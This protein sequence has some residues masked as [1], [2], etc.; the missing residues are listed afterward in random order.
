MEHV[1]GRG[2]DLFAAACDQ[3]LEGTVGK[4]ADGQYQSDGR[5]TSWVK[6]KNPAYSQMDGRRELLEARRM[7]PRRRGRLAAPELSLR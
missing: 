1:A 3:D 6:I 5:V 7:E 4:W 2:R